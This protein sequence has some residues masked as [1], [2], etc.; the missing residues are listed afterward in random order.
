MITIKKQIYSVACNALLTVC[1]VFTLGAC[2]T[3]TEKNASSES[4]NA[5]SES[6][7]DRVEPWDGDP[8][9]IPMDGSSE[10]AFEASLAR[11]EAHASPEQYTTLVNAIDYLLLYDL[12]AERNKQKLINRLDGLTAGEVI[13]KVAWRKPIPPGG[14]P[15][16]P[17]E[18]PGSG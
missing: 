17:E 11:V 7:I 9:D 3:V 6:A 8:M 13:D 10:E 16:V 14:L 15:E 2:S 18:G 1:L 4:E 12:A 5:P